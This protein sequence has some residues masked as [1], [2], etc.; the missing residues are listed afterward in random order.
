MIRHGPFSLRLPAG[1]QDETVV[2]L[3][4]NVAGP[5][6]SR[7]LKNTS[8]QRMSFVVKLAPATTQEITLA[9]FADAQQNL[10]KQ[11]LP[12]MRVVSRAET[13][14]A[15]VAA[16]AVEYAFSTP[17]G[18]MQQW[19]AYGYT[20]GYFFVVAGTAPVGEPYARAKAD[21]LA[22]AASITF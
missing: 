14:V 9:E 6:D 8:S 3:A 11:L 16:I 13:Q 4:A 10:M 18:A 20:P 22:L 19:Q 12:D 7:L 17:E 5:S 2:T 1:W 21:F 15:G